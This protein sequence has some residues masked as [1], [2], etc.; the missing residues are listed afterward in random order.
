MVRGNGEKEC[1]WKNERARCDDEGIGGM[2]R[3]GLDGREGKGGEG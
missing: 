2:G 3:V 1:D